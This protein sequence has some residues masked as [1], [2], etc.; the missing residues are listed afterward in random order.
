MLWIPVSCFI[1]DLSLY[2]SD[3]KDINNPGGKATLEEFLAMGKS[4]YL[5]RLLNEYETEINLSRWFSSHRHEGEKDSPCLQVSQIKRSLKYSTQ[6]RSLYQ[7]L[8]RV[9]LEDINT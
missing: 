2:T 9:F 8:R 5:F 4:C 7:R 3:S 1:Y 6:E